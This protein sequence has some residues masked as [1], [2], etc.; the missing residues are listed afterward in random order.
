MDRQLKLLAAG[1]IVSIALAGA[2]F[3]VPN[4]AGGGVAEEKPVAGP[5]RLLITPVMLPAGSGPRAL[6]VPEPIQLILTVKAHAAR[7]VCALEPRIHDALIVNGIGANANA[8]RLR[9][10]VD[11]GLGADVKGDVL[12]VEIQP[13]PPILAGEVPER[14]VS[15]DYRCDDGVLFASP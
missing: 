2:A 6:P 4:Y 3:V 10:V 12:D 14:D 15:F 9:A 1:A 7:R 11:R 8:R 13:G 5:S